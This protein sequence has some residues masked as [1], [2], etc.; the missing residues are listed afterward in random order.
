LLN[1]DKI[2][3]INLSIIAIK[4]MSKLSTSTQLGIML[5]S[6]R[7]A[8]GLTQSDIA[9][10]LGISQNR[11]SELEKQPSQLSVD[12]LLTLS[13]ILGLELLLQERPQDTSQGSEW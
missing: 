2:D 6:R 5:A 7:K 11:F 10:R 12:R 4:I 13:G 8:L 1:I 3:I 9:I